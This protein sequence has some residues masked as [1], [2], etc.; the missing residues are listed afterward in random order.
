MV[1]VSS[2]SPLGPVQVSHRPAKASGWPDFAMYHPIF[3]AAPGARHYGAELPR[4]ESRAVFEGGR[5]AVAVSDGRIAALLAAD[6]D[7]A[8]QA[9]REE[10]Q[11]AAHCDGARNRADSMTIWIHPAHDRRSAWKSPR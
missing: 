7:P 1:E 10:L 4:A 3:A 5:Q 11:M 8:M 9:A 2:S 6:L